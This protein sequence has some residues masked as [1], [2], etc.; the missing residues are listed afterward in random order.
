MSKLDRQLAASLTAH[1][2]GKSFS[3]PDAGRLA[4]R[5]FNDLSRTRTGTGYGPNPLS[6]AEIEAYA[7]L[8][9]WPLEP[10]HVDLILALDRAFLDHVARRQNVNAAGNAN[11]VDGPPIT[12]EGIDAIFGKPA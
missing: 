2:A 4:W 10:R 7:R 6:Y 3:V 12:L 8:Y 9:R 1:L 11:L 5:W